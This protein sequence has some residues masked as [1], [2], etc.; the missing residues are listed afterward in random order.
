MGLMAFRMG[1]LD[2]I[3]KTGSGFIDS[4]IC[5]VSEDTSY[6]FIYSKKVFASRQTTSIEIPPSIQA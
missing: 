5:R 6:L 4:R 2:M 1:L 3:D